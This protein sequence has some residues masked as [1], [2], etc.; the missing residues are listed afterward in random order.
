MPTDTVYADRDCIDSNG[1]M[2][3]GTATYA[4]VTTISFKGNNDYR[5]YFHFDLSAVDAAAV[6]SAGTVNLYWRGGESRSHDMVLLTSTWSEGSGS[7][8]SG[9][10]VLHT[11][12]A[13]ASAGYISKDC[14]STIQDWVD[15]GLANHGVKVKC[16]TE[17][18]SYGSPPTDTFAY[19]TREE[20]GTSNDPYISV[21]WQIE[22]PA[23]TASVGVS[24][25]TP[26]VKVSPRGTGTASVGAAAQAAKPSVGPRGGSAVTTAAQAA[27]IRVSKQVTAAVSVLTQARDAAAKVSPRV[28]AAAV[29]AAAQQ[30]TA[31]ATKFVNAGVA[32]VGTTAH[33]PQVKVSPRVA[34]AALVAAA[35]DATV[36]APQHMRPSGDITTSGWANEVAGT[37][38]LYQS[39]DET[40]PNDSDYVRATAP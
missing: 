16:T 21:T 12:T 28:G 37:T 22:A 25:P 5:A 35:K 18:H 14:L 17:D 3:N 32:G 9:S 13:P 40:T 4:L 20:S 38:N 19:A 11:Y 2:T 26:Q 31:G 29:G 10:T 6:C 24:A 15:G 1:T 27:T 7:P 33:T 36:S 39:V 8:P 34:A 23:G 30:A